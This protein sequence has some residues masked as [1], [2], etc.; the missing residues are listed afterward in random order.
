MPEA[1]KPLRL[2]SLETVRVRRNELLR[3]VEENRAE[4]AEIFEKALE[5]WQKAVT[6]ALKQAY[7]DARAGREYTTDLGLQRPADHT[8]DYDQVIEM[9][10]MS[11]DD[12]L[13]LPTQQFVQFVMDE[14]SWQSH[15]LTVT[16]GYSDAAR[17]KLLRMYREAT[18]W[19]G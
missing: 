2:R 15:F 19:Y 1:V 13:E 3:R 4:H 6:T 16:S 10:K 17:D 8:K 7:A 12:E 9:L 18:P 14:W 5:G 11:Q